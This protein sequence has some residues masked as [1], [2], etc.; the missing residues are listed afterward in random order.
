MFR[1]CDILFLIF[2][3]YKI[4]YVIFKCIELKEL[5]KGKVLNLY[6]KY[7]YIKYKYRFVFF[8]VCL[9]EMNKYI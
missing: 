6:I 9:Y 2:K 3:G 1:L 4:Y 8:F 7:K 5:Y